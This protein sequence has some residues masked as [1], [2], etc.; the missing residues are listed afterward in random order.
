MFTRQLY[1]PFLLFIIFVLVGCAAVKV[2]GNRIV[3]K[4]KSFECDLLGGD[5]KIVANNAYSNISLQFFN[6][7]DLTYITVYTV[8]PKE[9]FKD[10]GGVGILSSHFSGLA[11]SKER[12]NFKVISKEEIILDNLKAGVGVAEYEFQ[13][14]PKKIKSYD[15]NFNNLLYQIIL[16]ADRENFDRHVSEFDNF[17]KTFKFIRK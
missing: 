1:K 10:L 16:F 12:S 4:P 3:H 11:R 7:R 8:E 15:T 2:V 13:G 9:K 5:W 14:I 17:V 6:K